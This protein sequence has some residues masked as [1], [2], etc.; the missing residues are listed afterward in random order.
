M[1][2]GQVL[3][4]G[5]V[6]AICGW[7]ALRS[8]VF[9]TIALLVVIFLRLALEG[10]LP[11]DPFWLALAA[12]LVA[13]VWWMARTPE[14]LSAFGA[15]EWAM[16]LYLLWN[17]ASALL[18]HEYPVGDELIKSSM[19]LPRF[20]LF[21]AAIPLTMY[22]VGRYTFDRTSAVRALLWAMLLMAGHSAATAIMPTIGLAQ[23]VWPQYPHD[24][25]AT[26]DWSGRAAGV[27]NQPVASGILLALGIAIAIQLVSRGDEPRLRRWLAIAIAVG[28]GYGL[29]LTH[30]RAAWLCGMVV[31]VMGAALARGYR[32]G[33]F[34]SLGF[35]TAVVI[36]KW[37]TFTSSDREAGGVGSVSEVHDRLNTMA[38]ALWAAER[39]PLEGWGIGRFRTV[40]TYHHQQWAPD[41]EWARGFNMVSH[42]NELGILAELGMIG[43]ALWL[44]VL[45]LC[46]Y[47]LC[48]AYR[49]L[50]SDSL[51]GK[52]LALTALTAIA[53][54]VVSGFTVDL[55]YL[56]F[57]TAAVFLLVGVTIG[58]TD[59]RGQTRWSA[60]EGSAATAEAV[61]CG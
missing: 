26:A 46:A 5:A 53:V 36:A 40:N 61:R 60:S 10:Y 13:S 29:Y 55:R 27:L 42:Q 14:R 19:A 50:P 18:P 47:R 43:L 6:A 33:Y 16:S 20:V 3:L 45:A 51:T 30:T 49:T 2:F 17:L 57:P 7:G 37:S 8:P 44:S 12:L 35:V 23:W 52:P 48:V 34:A 1:T 21:A 11:I 58:W 54:L 56:G 39:K 9:A 32:G 38:T 28:C 4:L 24:K 22:V 41:V 15:I 25:D 31:L 59:R